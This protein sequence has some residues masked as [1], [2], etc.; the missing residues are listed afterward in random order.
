[1]ELFKLSGRIS[2]GVCLKCRHNT[3]GRYC[4]YCKEG[5][6]RDPAKPITHRKACKGTDIHFFL[7]LF[8]P[9]TTRNRI[10][11]NIELITFI[12]LDLYFL[13]HTV[14]LS[15]S[16]I[17]TTSLSITKAIETTKNTGRISVESIVGCDEKL[18]DLASSINRPGEMLEG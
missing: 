12:I 5:Y 18:I 7:F 13:N 8:F 2:G 4:H 10:H 9:K 15:Y 17:L 3:A 16:I 11:T 14:Y 6:Y 1:M